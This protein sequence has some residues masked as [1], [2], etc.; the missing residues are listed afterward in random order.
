MGR[1]A[2]KEMPRRRRLIPWWPLGTAAGL[3]AALVISATAGARNRHGH[4]YDP[5]RPNARF[6]SPMVLYGSCGDDSRPWKTASML[7]PSGSIT[8]PA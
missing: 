6:P 8:Y 1:C 5:P 4:H 7:L 2:A 3:T